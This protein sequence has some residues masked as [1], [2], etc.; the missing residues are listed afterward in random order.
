[1]CVTSQQGNGRHLDCLWT[2]SRRIRQ[3]EVMQFLQER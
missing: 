1:M 3:Y 2:M